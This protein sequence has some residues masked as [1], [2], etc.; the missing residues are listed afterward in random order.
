MRKFVRARLNRDN[1]WNLIFWLGTTC[2]I[3]VTEILAYL[4]DIFSWLVLLT[5]IIAPYV[6][7]RFNKVRLDNKKLHNANGD[8]M[9]KS[10]HAI[11]AFSLWLSI[12]FT[13][14]AIFRI[15]DR[16][17]ALDENIALYNMIFWFIPI[18]YCILKNRPIS[19]MFNKHAWVGDGKS[20]S[21]SNKKHGTGI[22]TSHSDVYCNPAKSWHPM[23]THHKR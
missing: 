7:S 14:L 1:V 15:H 3:L 22:W 6:F 11:M 9:P 17:P 8:I 18:M 23:N 16:Y 4:S 10:A 19:L 13:V 2:S 21:V 12:P 20:R 5:I